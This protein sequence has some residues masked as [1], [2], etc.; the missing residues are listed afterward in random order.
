MNEIF[1]TIIVDTI[2]ISVFVKNISIL[3]ERLLEY[4]QYSFIFLKFKS[5]NL[6][7]LCANTL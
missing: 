3:K 5:L 6:E 4:L 7:D 1:N 2:I